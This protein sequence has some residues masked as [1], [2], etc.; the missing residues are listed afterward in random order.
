MLVTLLTIPKF[1]FQ[2]EKFLTQTLTLSFV[3]CLNEDR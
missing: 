1:T 2:N 3:M